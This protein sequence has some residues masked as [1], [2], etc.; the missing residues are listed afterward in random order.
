MTRIPASFLATLLSINLAFAQTPTAVP[1]DVPTTAANPTPSVS[2]EVPAGEVIKRTFSASHLF[3]GTTRTYSIYIPREYDP[4]KPACLFVDQD[5]VQFNSPAVFDQLIASKEMPVTIGVFIAPGRV[6]AL[7]PDALDRFNR[8]YEYDTRSDLYVRFLLEELLPDVEKQTA[9]DGRAIHLSTDR[10]DRCIAGASSGAICAFT[11]AWERPD[12]F[13]RVFSSIGTY[14][15]LRGGNEYPT[16]IRKSEPLP[17]RIFL[18]DGN[19]D[20]NA[21]GGNWFLANQ[22]M[23]S[24]LTFA[25]Y[26]VNHSWGTGGHNPKHATEIFPEAMRWI[27]QGWPAPITTGL[28]SPQLRDIL[29]PNEP[30]TEVKRLK[31]NGATAADPGLYEALAEEPKKED[32]PPSGRLYRILSTDGKDKLF[33]LKTDSTKSPLDTGI[34]FPGGVTLS[35]DRS[36]LYLT[37]NRSH[38]VYSFQVQTDGT[39]ALKQQYDH[40]HMPDTADDAGATAL[41][42]DQNGRLYAGTRMGV[43]VCD[44]A[45]RVNCIIPTPDHEPIVLL[46][47][48]AQDRSILVAT[49]ADHIY[50]RHL[51]VAGVLSSDP[52]LKPAAP[53]L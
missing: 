3:P 12:S 9:T 53:H 46:Q 8:S 28:G 11:A 2:P 48:S 45:G 23:E 22:E 6:P 31:F 33:L 16:L 30:W 10:K 24:A 43:Q 20:Q 27:W 47:F 29:L 21:C 7:S 18:E 26:E 15:G 32:F 19:A 51:K 50:Q 34:D 25:G 40:L 37:D 38:W 44:Q 39:L 13:S 42:V 5:G 1:S 36:L 4:A 41:C 52:P 35:P 17:L 49:T 14:V